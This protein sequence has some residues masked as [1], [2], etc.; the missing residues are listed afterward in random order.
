MSRKNPV[1]KTDPYEV[2]WRDG[3]PVDRRTLSALVRA[4]RK[5]KMR[6]RVVQGSYQELYGGGAS[7]SAHT[8]DRGGVID[9]SVAGMTRRQRIRFARS[10][11]RRGFAIWYRSGPGW[12]G[13]EH[14]HAVLRWH[15]NLH[16]E[17]LAQ[18]AD[19]DAGRNGLV[20]HLADRTW[21]P[22]VRRHWSHRQQRIVRERPG[23]RRPGLWPWP[24]RG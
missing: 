17:A 8:H 15:R 24:K 12:V 20:S 4:E 6:V 3:E 23:E 22:L 19:Y 10:M 9:I 5:A 2:V 18:E 13:N 11:K 7:A 14:F 1:V 16:P 21:R